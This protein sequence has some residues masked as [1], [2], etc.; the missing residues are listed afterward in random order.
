MGSFSVGTDAGKCGSQP[1]CTAQALSH[2][3]LAETTFLVLGMRAHRL[4][5][6]GAGYIIEPGGL[7]GSH[8]DII[9]VAQDGGSGGGGD[10]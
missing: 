9:I 8:L 2:D 6:R 10:R 4:E 5:D 1:L 7:E 3:G